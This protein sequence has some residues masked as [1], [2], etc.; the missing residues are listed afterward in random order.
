ML[1]RCI[2]KLI[3]S[4]DEY[5]VIGLRA[6]AEGAKVTLELKF[7]FTRIYLKV[8]LYQGE[9]FALKYNLSLTNTSNLA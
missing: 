4:K 2:Y 6:A 7:Y 3:K 8:L 9:K 1:M 5:T